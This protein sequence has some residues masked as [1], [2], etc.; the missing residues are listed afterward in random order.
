[1][2]TVPAAITAARA[3]PASRLCKIW[4]LER[5]DGTVLRFT[6]HDRAL[7]VDGETYLPTA[8]FD[9]S[10]IKASGD[11]AV[12]DLDVQGAFDSSLITAEDLMA[13]RYNGATFY[14]AEVLWDDPAAGKDVQRFGWLG[15]VREQGGRFVAEL[16]GPTVRLQ[17][18][19][20]DVYSPGCRATLGDSR[21]KVD[22][23]PF[24]QSGAVATVYDGRAFD[25]SG[26]TLPD[27]EYFHFGLVTW[28]SGANAG[29]EMEVQ[30]SDG[31]LV[32]LFLPMPFPIEVGDTFDIVA[33]CNKALGT[34]RVKFSN[35]PNFRGHPHVPVS[36]DLIKGPGG[37]DEPRVTEPTPG[38]G[39][40]LGPPGGGTSTPTIPDTWSGNIARPFSDNSPWN[41]PVPMSASYVDNEESQKLRSGD[42]GSFGVNTVNWS[43][44]VGYATGSTA[45]I[46]VLVHNIYGS[47]PDAVVKVPWPMGLVPTGGTDRH[48]S[49]Y[50]PDGLTIHEMWYVYGTY[51]NFTCSAYCRTKLAGT[52][53]NLFINGVLQPQNTHSGFG[54]PRA[55]SVSALGGLIRAGEVLS[56]NINH[57]LVMAI[58][59]HWLKGD[60]PRVPPANPVNY[61]DGT[62]V[63]NGP[64]PYSRRFAIPRSVNIASLGLSPAYEKLG[65][66]LQEYGTYPGD[67]S[68][69]PCF[70]AENPAGVADGS[71]LNAD[72]SQMDLLISNLR[73]VVA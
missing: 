15:R 27:P 5:T 59:F 7:E 40:V 72:S 41:A 46:D 66:A 28:T 42:R 60:G 63:S 20:L 53:W 70:Y 71:A 55:V 32:Q 4:R 57:A 14:V 62:S 25:A 58:P 64:I 68:E 39:T 56:G 12:D 34:C 33:G 43:I 17:S 36:D 11:L 69:N 31:T 35:V 30:G 73:V 23:G 48:V 21:C 24:T 37:Q 26:L 38:D 50:D 49:I 44:A 51:P 22:L 61:R 2:R 6:E 16:L 9:P 10:T 1:M 8:S 19:L 45:L 3:T 65:Y 47:H 52:G 67:V 54:A 29:L 18:A 13:G